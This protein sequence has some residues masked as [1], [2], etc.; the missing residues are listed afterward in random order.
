LGAVIG[1]NSDSDFFS[2]ALL[3]LART[4]SVTTIAPVIG[5]RRDLAREICTYAC[6]LMG[7]SISWD[8]VSIR[9]C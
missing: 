9:Q 8:E 7:A 2:L 6:R 4:M 1:E 5:L 3:S